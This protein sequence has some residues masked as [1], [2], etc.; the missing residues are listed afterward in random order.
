[1]Y[2]I[3]ILYL[4]GIMILFMYMC[5]ISSVSKIERI[6]LI[7][8]LGTIITLMVLFLVFPSFYFLRPFYYSGAIYSLYSLGRQSVLIIL[9]IYLILGLLA[10]IF[11]IEKLQGPLKSFY[12]KQIIHS[13]SCQTFRRDLS[14]FQLQ[15][16]YVF[17]VNSIFYSV[18]FKKP[19]PNYFPGPVRSFGPFLFIV[20][21]DQDFSFRER[22]SNS[23]FSNSSN[24]Y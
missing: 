20:S 17:T 22:N 14:V 4:G 2:T 24:C 9:G 11:F 21:I 16:C 15:K 6:S 7:F 8:F 19:A 23:I 13:D 12:A 1:M 3:I 10:R 18:F 5:R